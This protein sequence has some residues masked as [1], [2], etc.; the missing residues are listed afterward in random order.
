MRSLFSTD[1]GETWSNPVVVDHKNGAFP[2]IA[3]LER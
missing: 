1:G 3:P 2:K